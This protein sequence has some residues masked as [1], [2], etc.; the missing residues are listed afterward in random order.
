MMKAALAAIAFL[1][2]LGA[3]WG[4]KPNIVVFLALEFC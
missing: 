4:E 1:V 3:V 2:Q